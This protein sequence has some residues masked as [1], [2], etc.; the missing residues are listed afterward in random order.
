MHGRIREIK[1][2]E[3]KIVNSVNV[4]GAREDKF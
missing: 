4:H 2:H 3:E 1:S